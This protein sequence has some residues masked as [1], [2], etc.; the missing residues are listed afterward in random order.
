MNL[1]HNLTLETPRQLL[2]SGMSRS[3]QIIASEFL[4]VGGGRHPRFFKA[5]WYKINVK[6]IALYKREAVMFF[7]IVYLSVSIYLWSIFFLPSVSITKYTHQN[8]NRT[9]PSFT[10]QK[11]VSYFGQN[12]S[13][14]EPK[15]EKSWFY[16][17]TEIRKKTY[18]R[19][20]WAVL[21]RR[22]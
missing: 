14:T 22:Y 2:K 11:T 4:G 17:L 21:V 13:S 1:N 5:Q 12:L 15:F 6:N 16:R 3:P 8:F 9:K 18:H 10:S 20:P 19:E 7:K